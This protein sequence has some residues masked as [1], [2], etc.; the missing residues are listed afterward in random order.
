ME[1]ILSA[2][3][4]V[5]LPGTKEEGALCVIPHIPEAELISPANFWGNQMM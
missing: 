1:S 4:T 3:K 2:K 5:V